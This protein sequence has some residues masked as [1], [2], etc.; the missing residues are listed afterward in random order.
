[1]RNGVHHRCLCRRSLSRNAARLRRRERLHRRRGAVPTG[2]PSLRGRLPP[3][4]RDPCQ[5]PLCDPVMGC[6]AVNAADGTSCGR[7]GRCDCSG[8][9]HR[10]ASCAERPVAEGVQCGDA[11]AVPASRPPA[12]PASACNRLPARSH[13]CWTWTGT[14]IRWRG[15]ADDAGNIY[16]VDVAGPRPKADLGFAD[17][18]RRP[19]RFRTRL[20]PAQVA[21]GSRESS[22]TR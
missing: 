1:M 12:A 19:P 9:V 4:R 21:R 5:V 3:A 10:P 11:L 7:R 22:P 17:T 15:L 16:F 18:D 20:P 14:E 8:R 13:P 6:I 2:M